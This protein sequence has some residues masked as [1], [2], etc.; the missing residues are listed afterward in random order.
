[1]TQQEK[2]AELDTSI[3]FTDEECEII[4]KQSEKTNEQLEELRI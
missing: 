1:M 4:E 2:Q 3:E